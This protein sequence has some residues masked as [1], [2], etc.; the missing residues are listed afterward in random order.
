MRLNRQRK[1]MILKSTFFVL[2]CI[3]LPV[4]AYPSGLEDLRIS[5]IDGDVQISTADTEEWVPA[6]IKMPLV[7]G[8]RIWVPEGSRAELQSV[9]GSYV[10]L[11][12]R[13]SLDVLT[14]ERH[15]FQFYLNAG[16][17]Y[18]NFSGAGD[19]LLQI[20]TPVSSIRAYDRAK[21]RIETPDDDSTRVS[22][23]SGVV[24]AENRN[25]STAL[26]EG[27]AL[28][29]S[30]QSYAEMSRLGP[31]DSWIRWNSDR[32]TRIYVRTYSRRYLPAELASYSYDFD[33]YGKWV[34]VEEY[35][36]CWTPTVGI[37]VGWAPYRV[38]RWAWIGGDYVWVSHEPWGWVPHHYG[39]W[40]FVASIGWCWLPPARGAIY[41][42]P[43]YVAWVDNPTYVA[44]VPL[45]PREI[46]YGHGYYGPHSVNITKVNVNK[47]VVKNV[48]KNV[49]VNNAVSVES[50][51]TFVTGRRVPVKVRD[52]PFIRDRISI[53]RPNIK[54][55]KRTRMPVIKEIPE[56][57]LPP[58]RI[59]EMPVRELKDR[60][61]L[62]KDRPEPVV[63]PRPLPKARV[64]VPKATAPKEP[65]LP[66]A[67]APL[68]R[69]PAKQREV[70]IPTEKEVRPTPEV[71]RKQIEPGPPLEKAIKP[72]EIPA[73]KK[74]GKGREVGQSPRMSG[75]K[76]EKIGRPVQKEKSPREVR[77]PAPRG[78]ERPSKDRPSG[79]R[80]KGKSHGTDTPEESSR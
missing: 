13:T 24:Y 21:F 30:G 76:R 3:L 62:V 19:S 34:Y 69:R 48:Y 29:F 12:D 5:L 56:A 2:L 66:Q 74:E 28:V 60:Y 32:D 16:D 31:P 40:T 37:S 49:Y 64:S 75:E 77:T 70:K 45:A 47:V 67:V 8:D 39:R 80:N 53:G 44:W 11:N 71:R 72:R 58:S 51:E 33:S 78:G 52:N 14:L 22:S 68:E 15:S 27:N 59:R 36:R 1:T 10:R 7:E 6:S 61:P 73:V 50:R 20:D 25:G 63:M 41:W 38:G 46:Y 9:D 17:V 43:G 55:E 26:T 57:K 4:H 54:P 42:G 35:G 79:E 18:V 23:F 65:K